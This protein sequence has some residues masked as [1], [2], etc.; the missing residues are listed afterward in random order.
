MPRK[1]FLN[2]LLFLTPILSAQSEFRQLPYPLAKIEIKENH[3]KVKASLF[4]KQKIISEKEALEN[5]VPPF[6]IKEIKVITNNKTVF[7][8]QYNDHSP[9]RQM[10][11]FT[12][13]KHK[14]TN[15]IFLFIKDNMENTQKIKIQPLSCDRITYKKKNQ[16]VN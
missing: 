9:E 7:Q 5:E 10:I 16:E 13:T 4:I 6:Y 3:N 11:H 15:S 12:F 1:F 8:R 14:K 2:F